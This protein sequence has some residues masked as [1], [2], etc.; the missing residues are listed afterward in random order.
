MAVP[1]P[2]TVT[3]LI[4]GVELAVTETPSAEVTLEL[5]IVAVTMLGLPAEPIWLMATETP[6]AAPTPLEPRVKSAAP[7]TAVIVDVSSASTSTPSSGPAL[8]VL[9]EISA[10]VVPCIV[11]ISKLPA[12]DRFAA[13]ATPSA[14]PTINSFV[15]ACTVSPP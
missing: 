7:A 11:S 10:E 4:V 5:S 12:S 3:A 1:E 9:S 2:A 8:T 15:I 14:I 6:I 13:P